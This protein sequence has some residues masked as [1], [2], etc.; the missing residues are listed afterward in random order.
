MLMKDLDTL[1]KLFELC[2]GIA[3]N[4][5]IPDEAE[6]LAANNGFIVLVGGSDDLMYA[7]GAKCYLTDQGELSYGWNGFDFSATDLN[8]SELK[9][10]TDI[11][12]LKIWWCGKIKHTGEILP[13]YDTDT[14]GAFSYSV[15]EGLLCKEFTVFE[16][17]GKPEVYCT[18]LIVKLPPEMHAQTTSAL[19]ISIIDS[20]RERIK[21]LEEQVYELKQQIPSREVLQQ[22]VKDAER[23]MGGVWQLAALMQY[24]ANIISPMHPYRN[25]YPI[26]LSKEL[27]DAMPKL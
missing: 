5:S 14:K 17:V 23:A 27:E 12:G 16:N 26:T 20:Q 10:E 11:L 6:D 3:Y 8:D 18:G 15:K 21:E 7:Y 24:D 4:R 9:R 2:N 1:N 22:R 25:K 13:W 19:A